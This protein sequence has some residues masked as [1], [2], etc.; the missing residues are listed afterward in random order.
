[1]SYELIELPEG[2]NIVSIRDITLPY[3][4]LQPNKEPEKL[5]KY[6]DISSI[7]N[8]K[9]TITEPKIFLGKD[10]PSRARRLVK[11]G[12]ILF[13]TVRTYLKN[14]ACVPPELDGV[15]TSTGIA[16]LRAAPGIYNKF[17]FYFVTS[18]EFIREI[19]GVMDGTLYPAVTDSDVA[20]AQII[21]PPLN[22]QKRIVAKIE[23]L[24]ERSRRAREA[25]FEIPG[26]C[27]RFR[28]SV[29]AAA[30]RGDLTADW[31]EQNPDV[32]PA[33]VF[34]EKIWNKRYYQQEKHKKPE[35]PD[36]EILPEIPSNWSWV[37][38]EHLGI[39]GEQT[40]LTSPFGATLGREDFVESGVPVRV[41]SKVV[42]GCDR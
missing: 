17:L 8:T 12:D 30:F 42:G 38:V 13:S 16:V 5:F 41:W 27:D 11:K 1:M 9:Q 18:D 7:D 33:S 32:E 34:F 22:E 21:L 35:L 25:L 36:L 4:T 3:T 28:Q 29:L 31:R 15:L 6:I 23:A 24:R 10:A 37:T 26:L 14:I 20:S 19:S 2:W 40:V 39:D